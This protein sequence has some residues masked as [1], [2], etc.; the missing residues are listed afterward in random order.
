MIGYHY[1]FFDH[2]MH[3]NTYVV[4][5]YDESGN[6]GKSFQNIMGM[7]HEIVEWMDDPTGGNP[8]PAWGKIGQD[9]DFQ[10]NLEVGDLLSGTVQIPSNTKAIYPCA[11]SGF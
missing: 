6:F 11:G 5:D 7:S 1:A 2:A 9:T 4:S 3:L 10:G 8:T